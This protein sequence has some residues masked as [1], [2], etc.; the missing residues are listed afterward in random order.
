MGRHFKHLTGLVRFYDDLVQGE[1][2]AALR[3]GQ[4]QNNAT[5][6]FQWSDFL[7]TSIAI[8]DVPLNG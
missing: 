7:G 4:P 3:E 6:K 8:V 1:T 5:I 2:W